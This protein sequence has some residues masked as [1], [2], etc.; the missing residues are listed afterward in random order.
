MNIKTILACGK[1]LTY[2]MNYRGPSIEPCGT[3]VCIG[4]M[5]DFMSSI[6]TNCSRFVKYLFSNC[7]ADDSNL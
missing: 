7:N 5:F 3:P 2:I 1:S 6:C 4:K